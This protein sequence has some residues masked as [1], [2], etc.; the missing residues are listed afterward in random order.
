MFCFRDLVLILD[1]FKINVL[2]LYGIEMFYWWKKK[3]FYVDNKKRYGL[4]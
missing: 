3:N 4:V 2:G 1:F